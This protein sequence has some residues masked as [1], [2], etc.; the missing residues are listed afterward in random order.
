MRNISL[1]TVCLFFNLISYAQNLYFKHLGI[2][3]GLSQVCTPAIYQDE[4]GAVWIGTSEGLNRYNGSSVSTY[5]LTDSLQT[6][7][8]NGIDQLCGNK[9]GQL[10]V[11]TQGKVFRFDLYQEKFTGLIGK[12]ASSLFCE[13]DTLWITGKDGIQFYTEKEK[14]LTFFTRFPKGLY[15]AN[16]IYA[17]KD[18]IWA[19]STARLSAIPRRHPEKQQ[20]MASF[21][22]ARCLFV[23]HSNNV[24]VG[25]WSGVYRFS[26]T[27]QVTH[28]TNDSGQISHNQIRSITED[29]TGNIWIGTFRGLDCYHPE[30]DSWSHY[31]EYGD[32]PN[33]LSHNSILHLHKDMQGNIWAGTYFGGVNVFNPNENNNYFYHAA[34]LR[35]DW[36]NFPVVGKIT[37]DSSGNLWIC[38][39][40]GGLNRLDARTGKF[41]HFTHQSDDPHSIGSNNLKSI[42]YH[43]GTQTLYVGTHFGG[44]YILN[45]RTGKG[46]TLRHV[47][48]DAS[49]LP[50]DIVNEIQ[51]YKQGLLILTQGGLVCMDLKTE[52]FFSVTSNEEINKLLYKRFTYET[53][54]LDSRQRLWLGLS[55]G[56]IICI[57][58]TSLHVSYYQSGPLS[59][60]T[61]CHIFEDRYGEIYVGTTGSGMFHYLRQDDQFK[62]YGIQDH[63]LPS[64]FCYY[65]GESAQRNCLYLIHGQ[66]IS[67]FNTQTGK[68]EN[69]FRM[70]NQ[71]Y[72]LGSSLFRD[73]KGTLYL[74]GTNGMAVLRNEKT[75]FTPQEV[76]FDR[77]SVFNQPIHP[78]D[79]SGIL[80]SILAKTQKIQL[81]HDQN[82]ITIEIAAFPYSN[83]INASFEYT[84]KGFDQRWN[85]MQ[86]THITYTHLT[87]GNYTL[88][89]RPVSSGTP[90]GKEISLDI[91][92]IPPFYATVWAY[93]LYALL[94]AGGIFLVFSFILRQ[95][96][97]R[98]S[99]QN[100]RKEKAHIEE[101]NRMK[102]NFFTNI[103]HEF[104]TPL[105]LILG[106][107]DALIQTDG[108]T[109]NLHNKLLRI[110]KNAWDM[111]KLISELLD[112][113]KH[114]QGCVQ[115]NAEEQDLVSFTRQV[116]HPFT[117]YARQKG[118]SFRFNA[119]M[120]TLPVWIDPLQMQKVISNL[121][122]NALKYT[123]SKG[124]ITVEI[125]KNRT[126]AAVTVADTG[127][128]ISPQ[129]L[130]HIFDQFYQADEASQTLTP[131][132]GIGL[133]IAKN[134][135]ELHHGSIEASSQPG[136][137]SR[138]TFTIPL[139]QLHFSPEELASPHDET[140]LM[141]PDTDSLLPA[142]LPEMED[143]TE[144]EE[145][146][147]K[148]ESQKPVL[149]L[150]ED[151]EELCDILK[152]ALQ[153]TYSLHIAHNGEE[154]WEKALELHPDL[155]ISD[156]IMNGMSGKELC[157]KIK[158]HLEMARTSVILMTAQ[159]S[160]EQMIEAL[161]FGADDYLVKPF[162][163]RIL[164]TRC[165]NLLKN[166]NRLMA[167]CTNQPAPET[168][169]EEAAS[170]S[171]KKL[172][173]QS[174]DIIRQNFTN[175]DFD[176]TALANALC[177]GRSKLYAKYK[178][179]VGL[180][181]NE[182]I[183]KI[184]LE[185]SM[186]LLKAHPDLNISEISAR[187]G[188][189]SPRYFSKQFKNLYGVTPQNV[190][191]K[192]EN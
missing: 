185:E 47:P 123:P 142:Y 158:S 150:V 75:K 175:P 183:L 56:G 169:A 146:E 46:H 30:T 154:G 34:P 147:E 38:T 160:T 82:N 16:Q 58:L 94:L 128:G 20:K 102:I 73:R 181:P 170:E 168:T 187:L 13:K 11:L 14:K 35:D 182:F 81:K 44:L 65:I 153:P 117:E 104:R 72:S 77:L 29:N 37:E 95:D 119:Q 145:E 176:V 6:Y 159:N 1:I 9:N 188:F 4:L 177:M 19:I 74:G 101:I 137:G 133:S 189:S 109:N 122:S 184:K 110:Y 61:V 125:R 113:R 139:G 93:L 149:L 151:N 8:S 49:S 3:E 171:D 7:T 112:F 105:T 69:T 174:I 157:Y 68:V 143:E 87:P 191:H 98:A 129:D 55:R 136:E 59:L 100:V 103:S 83:D 24:W 22:D 39:E 63:V 131:G 192:Q 134:I 108:L 173:Q 163:M 107:L 26:P 164:L 152:D 178:Q 124:S 23:D 190:R 161:R 45:T 42:Y 27:R 79:K 88:K 148:T 165:H 54:L 156:V 162:D 32:S 167:F 116:C 141:T 155:V 186:A 76:R 121:L 2:T 91:Q 28:Y 21:N 179:L 92:V 138:F 127:C 5:T 90:E 70:F 62:Q 140:V 78:G 52:K 53:F 118:I 96:R 130:P 106:Q 12:N 10:Y 86:G 31:T 71:S 97:L 115:L 64:N 89:V 85:R 60:N 67:L 84:L 180:P 36:L 25:S 48:G 33:T 172:L 40:G 57:D 15:P 111:L 144:K 166:K 43:P 18:T 66:G 135:V 126:Q 132:T 120:E 17:T 114:E 99:L 80:S 50:H 41:T 51:P